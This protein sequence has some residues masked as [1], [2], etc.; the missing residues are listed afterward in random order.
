MLPSKL[1]VFLLG[2]GASYLVKFKYV[3]NLLQKFFVQILLVTLSVGYYL[4]FTD[5]SNIY[6]DLILAILV[7]LMVTSLSF[8]S[9]VTKVFELRVI[10]FIGGA[11]FSIYLFHVPIIH[12]FDVCIMS[13]RDNG[14]LYFLLVLCLSIAIPSLFYLF[15]EKRLNISFKSLLTK[16][17]ETIARRGVVDQV[18]R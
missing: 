4:I 13:V 18:S 16:I 11:S 12:M 6:T 9:W 5:S 1:H 7:A 14:S 10:R 3:T 8:G 15:L 17:Y 2:V